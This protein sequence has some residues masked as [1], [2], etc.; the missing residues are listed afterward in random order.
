MATIGS[1]ILLQSGSVQR[2]PL[3]L[4]IIRCTITAASFNNSSSAIDHVMK[5]ARSYSSLSS[6]SPVCWSTVPVSHPV[7]RRLL[8]S[9]SMILST[10]KP[11]KEMKKEE[12][13]SDGQGSV[14]M[15]V[16]Q[17][18]EQPKAVTVGAK[19]DDLHLFNI[20]YQT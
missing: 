18:K 17:D 16:L 9:S 3:Q 15:E 2:L 20:R 7:L 6:R 1:R 5:V 12:R 14:L 19:G 4:S 11:S 10:A 13:Q 8:H